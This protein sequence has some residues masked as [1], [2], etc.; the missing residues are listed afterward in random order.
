MAMIRIATQVLVGLMLF[1]GT[2]TLVPRAVLY[3]KQ[4]RK[5]RG[6]LYVCLGVLAAVFAVVAFGTAYMGFAQGY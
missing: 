6:L 5:A 2:A 4:G 1:F 3:L